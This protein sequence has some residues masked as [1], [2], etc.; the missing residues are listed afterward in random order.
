MRLRWRPVAVDELHRKAR[1]EAGVYHVA[2][3]SRLLAAALAAN[4][5]HSALPMNTLLPL[6]D[7]A[8]ERAK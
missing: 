3:S 4:C 6:I 7:A 5:N 8:A 2:P 1:H